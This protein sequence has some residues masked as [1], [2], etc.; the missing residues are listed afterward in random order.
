MSSFCII[1]LLY[2]SPSTQ[3]SC[4]SSHENLINLQECLFQPTGLFSSVSNILL[5]GRQIFKSLGT[6]MWVQSKGTIGKCKA[7]KTAL[8]K[9]LLSSHEHLKKR[10]FQ[11][12]LYLT[13]LS[14]TCGTFSAQF[15]TKVH[16]PCQEAGG[17][18]RYFGHLFLYSHAT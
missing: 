15:T 5:L 10:L 16:T 7:L 3:Q 13:L 2:F 1:L 12:P 8:D 6:D 9:K 4:Q 11:P 17:A 18:H 14:H